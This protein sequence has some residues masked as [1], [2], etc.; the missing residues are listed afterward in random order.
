MRIIKKSLEKTIPLSER[1]R[2]S[3]LALV[4]GIKPR[5]RKS[6]SRAPN[7]DDRPCCK[8]EEGGAVQPMINILGNGASSFPKLDSLTIWL[9]GSALG[10]KRILWL[11]ASSWPH[12]PF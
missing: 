6:K 2:V 3:T 8:L 5:K 10:Q 12:L 4:G 9:V 7:W 1:N 11:F